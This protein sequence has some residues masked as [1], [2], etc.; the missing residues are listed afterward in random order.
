ML[1]FK[2]ILISLIFFT[3]LISCASKEKKEEETVIPKKKVEM[4]KKK[5]AEA[6]QGQLFSKAFNDRSGTFDFAQS[7]SL[8]RASIKALD[9]VPLQ[10]ISYSGGIIVTDWYSPKNSSESI[11]ITVN[12]SS[13]ELSV[14]SVSVSSFKKVCKNMDSC[15][16][17]K[18]NESFN[19]KIK[20]SIIQEARKIE[21][22]KK[23]K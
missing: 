12:F 1:I 18:M 11:K 3:V 16:I 14:S 20:D 17:S 4:D 23:K 7:N 15:I 2:K 21:I 6:Y 8:W 22:T 19:N 10:S 9:F 5:A 13:S